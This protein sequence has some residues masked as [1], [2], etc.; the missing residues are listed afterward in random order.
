MDHRHRRPG[1]ASTSARPTAGWP[2]SSPAPPTRP[3]SSS[4][5]GPT[6]CSPSPTPTGPR[7]RGLGPQR[8]AGLRPGPRRPPPRRGGRGLGPGAVA[9]VAA[10]LADNKSWSA[11]LVPAYG[12]PVALRRLRRRRVARVNVPRAPRVWWGDGGQHGAVMV[13]PRDRAGGA[14]PE[15]AL[16]RVYSHAST[17]ASSGSARLLVDRR[18]EAEEVRPG[19]VRRAP[20]PTSSRVRGDD[21]LP[22]VRRAVVNLYAAASGR[23]AG[24][25]PDRRRAVEPRRS[26]PV[27][28]STGGA[29]AQRRHRALAAS[30]GAWSCCASTT[31]SPCPRSPDPRRRRGRSEEPPP[32]GR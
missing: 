10:S 28:R 12:D 23:R 19:G 15:D 11:P 6:R 25:R 29:G 4:A 22:Y 30:G 26:E 32:P 5:R 16:R 20:G 17:H 8:A 7:V 13:E 9:Q 18:E 1:A 21:P 3:A 24:D 2:S 27:R 14:R 31:T